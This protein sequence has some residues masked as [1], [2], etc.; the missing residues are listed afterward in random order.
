VWLESEDEEEESEASEN[1]ASE[2]KLKQAHVA[3]K[4]VLKSGINTGALK[5]HVSVEPVSSNSSSPSKYKCPKCV[6]GF[7]FDY[8]DT[9][10]LHL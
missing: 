2:L 3:N 1:E 10:N 5:P 8:E 7:E 6:S 9:L 4:Q